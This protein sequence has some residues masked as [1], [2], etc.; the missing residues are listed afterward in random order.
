MPLV[1][2]IVVIDHHE[3]R[4]YRTNLK[5]AHA[6]TL[7]PYDPHHFHSHLD[8]KQGDYRG[9]RA[10][11][12][13]HYYREIAQ[14]LAGADEILILG[15]GKGHSSAKLLLLK[16]LSKHHPDVLDHV[17][18]VESIDSITENQVLDHAREFFHAMDTADRDIQ[19]ARLAE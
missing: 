16:Y 10:P 7:Q 8:H 2:V 19:V 18:G 14:A 4:M 3:A 9:Q 15:H 1:H 17:V 13:P 11:E 12:D 5:G 6:E